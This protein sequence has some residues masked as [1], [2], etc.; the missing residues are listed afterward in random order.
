MANSRQRIVE[1]ALQ[2]LKENGFAGASTRAIA[3]NGGFKPGLIFYYFPT[4]NDL[5]LAALE[6]ASEERL[7]RYG[8]EVASAATLGELVTLLERIY[9]DDRESGFIRVVSELVAG[10]V[11]H[12]ELGPRLVGLIEPWIAAAQT[13][14][15]RV[16]APTGLADLVPPRQ[17]VFAAV[18]FYLGANLLAQLV[19]DS[20]EIEEILA[21]GK[22]LAP[23]LDLFGSALRAPGEAQ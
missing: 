16:L 20:R 17:L 2:T 1:A 15:E 18:T 7:T 21:T 23:L 3:A 13:A 4:L 14:A 10:S 12:P 19:P 22:R 11:A 6:H 8:E 9:R 5:L